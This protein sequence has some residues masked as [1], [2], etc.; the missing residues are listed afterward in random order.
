MCNYGFNKS[1]KVQE[2]IE[3]YGIYPF[4]AFGD[5]QSDVPLLENSEYA[6]CIGH[7]LKKSKYKY[8]NFNQPI[9]VILKDILAS[10]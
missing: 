9:E 8:V 4:L 3:Q 5:S 7:G 2:L 6:I 10:F 1:K